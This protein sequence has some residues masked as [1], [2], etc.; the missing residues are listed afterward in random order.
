[1]KMGK[2]EMP[3]LL[4]FPDCIIFPFFLLVDG[5]WFFKAR[6][7]WTSLEKIVRL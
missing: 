7:L 5:K 1:M 2:I 3:K 6:E 4:F